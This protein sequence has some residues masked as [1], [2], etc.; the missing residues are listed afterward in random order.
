MF[1]RGTTLSLAIVTMIAGMTAAS[2]GDSP[3]EPGPNPTGGTPTSS[4]ESTIYKAYNAPDFVASTAEDAKTLCAQAVWVASIEDGNTRVV[5]TGTL[6]ESGAGS[7]SFS[8]SRTPGDRLRIAYGDGTVTEFVI[9]SFSGDFSD[10]EALFLNRDHRLAFTLKREGVADLD[11]S[12]EQV[13]R[14][15]EERVRG[16]LAFEGVIYTLDIT[17]QMKNFFD[18]VNTTSQEKREATTTGT[19]TAPDLSI[20]VNEYNFFHRFVS[21]NVVE[22]RQRRVRSTWTAGSDRYAFVNG[23]ITKGLTNN[24]PAFIDT[25]WTAV[26]TITRNGATV[27][28]IS[29][30]I[31][32]NHWKLA[33]DLSG[34]RIE[35]GTF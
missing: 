24:S 4:T 35:L 9:G 16:T 32:G 5:T 11:I 20:S 8:Y 3:S 26:G 13:N 12:S 21:N 18:L 23:H 7:G 28:Q 17:A 19:I 30:T 27:G 14:T 2:C 10:D 34:K 31:E 25:D 29:G 15:S 33:A 22:S 1:G 6:T